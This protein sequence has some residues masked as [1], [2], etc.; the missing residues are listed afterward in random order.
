MCVSQITKTHTRKNV[1][2]M[3]MKKKVKAVI[4]NMPKELLLVRKKV[5]PFKKHAFGFW[6]LRLFIVAVEQA[7]I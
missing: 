1:I 4:Y 6:M 7:A 2:K 5:F 3:I